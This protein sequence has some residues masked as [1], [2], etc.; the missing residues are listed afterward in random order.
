MVR[1]SNNDLSSHASSPKK[2]NLDNYLKFVA[3]DAVWFVVGKD[4]VLKSNEQVTRD[5]QD[6]F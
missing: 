1:Q 4:D 5:K 6:W 2:K 3:L